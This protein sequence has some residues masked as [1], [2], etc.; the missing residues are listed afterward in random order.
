[1]MYSSYMQ[2]YVTKTENLWVRS[3]LLLFKKKSNTKPISKEEI[4]KAIREF[5]PRKALGPNCFN[6]AFP[7]IVK[8][9]V[10]TTFYKLS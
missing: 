7:K 4:R 3:F 9:Q 6:V 2:L 8:E 1:M 5:F 10:I